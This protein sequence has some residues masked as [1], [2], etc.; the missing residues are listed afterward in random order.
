MLTP[1]VEGEAAVRA[2]QGAQAERAAMQA[3]SILPLQLVLSPLTVPFWRREAEVAADLRQ[4]SDAPA[5]AV[6]EE[7]AAAVT[8]APE[9]AVSMAVAAR[10]IL[11]AGVGA[12]T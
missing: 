11:A 9:A 2:A 8:A 12:A 10:P 3:L 5:A 7:E 4:M 6:V 1:Q